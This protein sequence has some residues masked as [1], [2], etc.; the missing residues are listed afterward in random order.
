MKTYAVRKQFRTSVQGMLSY[1]VNGIWNTGK[2]WDISQTG[3]RITGEHLLPIGLETIVFLTLCNG[4]ELH[5]L[6]IESAIVR[7][8]DGH[9]AGWEIL[10]IDA[11]SQVSLADVMKQRERETPDAW[12]SCEMSSGQQ[13]TC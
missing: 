3:C 7:W 13:L 1:P 9:H 4:D 6:L 5:H 11:L 2:V 10:R 8:S 12:L